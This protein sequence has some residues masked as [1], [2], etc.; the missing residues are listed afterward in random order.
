MD[1]WGRHL[2]Q[3]TVGRRPLGGGG[4]GR[5]SWRP[6]TRGVAPPPPRAAAMSSYKFTPRTVASPDAPQKPL[7]RKRARSGGVNWVQVSRDE[8]G[9]KAKKPRTSRSQ[10][11]ACSHKKYDILTTAEA[12]A[13]AARCGIERHTPRRPR[14]MN[15]W[16]HALTLTWIKTSNTTITRRT[17]SKGVIER[18]ILY[19][20]GVCVGRFAKHSSSTTSI[21]QCDSAPP[22]HTVMKWRFLADFKKSIPPPPQ[23]MTCLHMEAKL[24]E[25]AEKCQNPQ[26]WHILNVPERY[27]KAIFC[28]F[29]STARCFQGLGQWTLPTPVGP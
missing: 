9:R 14:N 6:R 2:W 12:T 21:Y 11:P 18:N 8:P 22:T 15:F 13:F 4:G 19:R 25:N 16:P 17:P 23:V 20:T 29:G 3:L 24:V 27:V 7:T 10:P 5:G 28:I 26:S 1:A